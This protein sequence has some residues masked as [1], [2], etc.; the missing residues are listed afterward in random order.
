M[1]YFISYFFPYAFGDYFF[2]VFK[3]YLL[4]VYK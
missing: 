1:Y 4:H 3:Y 2:C